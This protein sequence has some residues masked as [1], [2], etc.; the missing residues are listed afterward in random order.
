MLDVTTRI[1]INGAAGERFLSSLAG[2]GAPVPGVLRSLASG[3]RRTIEVGAR[4]AEIVAQF[5]ERLLASGWVDLDE[6]PLLYSPRVGDPV[7]VRRDVLAE[8]G[9]ELPGLPPTWRF[10]PAGVRG[11]LLGWRDRSDD[12]RAIVAIHELDRRLIV[13][14]SERHITRAQRLVSRGPAV[15]RRRRRHG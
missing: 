7:V 2:Y 6:P 4:D 8:I 11:K 10:V 5:V 14:V 1:T 12:D 13:L 9:R 3:H 15:L